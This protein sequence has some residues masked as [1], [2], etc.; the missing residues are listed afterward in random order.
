MINVS[1]DTKEGL[2]LKDFFTKTF[3]YLWKQSVPLEDFQMENKSEA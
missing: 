2:I 1:T 3:D